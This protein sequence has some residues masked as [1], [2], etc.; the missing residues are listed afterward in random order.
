[1]EELI[2]YLVL[3]IFGL[4]M[5]SFAGALVWRLRAFQLKEEKNDGEKINDS[6]YEKLEKLTK[7][8][9]KNDYS[10]CLNCSYKLKWYDLIPLF[11]WI[12]LKGKCRHC[13]KKIGYMEPAVELF[14]ALFF[15]LS[16]IYWPESLNTFFG[17]TSFILWLIAGVG[18]AVLFVYDVK[19]YLL[20]NRVSK[21]VL[22]VGIINSL[23]VLVQSN[24]KFHSIISIL[25]ALFI[26]SGLYWILHKI[27]KGKWI[28]FGDVELGLGLALMLADWRLAFIA[29]F[30]ANFIGC[31]I[32]LPPLL[33]GKLERNSKIPFGPLLIIGFIFAKLAGMYLINLYFYSLI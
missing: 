3:I 21:F 20:P 22:F 19:W 28:G 27:S 24:D 1:M 10:R 8:K 30:M 16:Y 2:I 31:L 14:T 12:S 9:V 6:E 33:A 5:G 26:L 15:V 11:S 18:L 25:F 17:F 13:H 7:N 4:C 32:V 23:I 29:L